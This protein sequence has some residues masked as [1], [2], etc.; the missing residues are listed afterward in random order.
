MSI[1]KRKGSPFYHYDF[2]WKGARQRGS[3]GQVKKYLADCMVSE[4]KTK[5]REK[6]VE[7]V[8]R[9]APTLEEFSKDFLEWV[10]AS[11]NIEENTRRVYGNGWR[12]LS[13]TKLAG[14]RM[15]EIANHHCETIQFPGSNYNANLALKTMRRMFSKAQEQKLVFNI[16]KIELRKVWGRS[17]AMSEEDA[18]RIAAQ[19]PE[20]DAKDALRILR[21]T[22]MRPCEAFAMRWEYVNAE[23]SIYRNPK[24]K[25]K[26]ARR[27]VPLFDPSGEILAR[28]RME[29]GS[30][31]EGWVFPSTSKGGHLVNIN[32]QFT[33]AR[34]AAGLPDGMVLYTARHGSLTDMAQVMT[35]CEVMQIGGHADSK[36][37]LRYQH[38]NTANI[39]ARLDNLKTSGRVQ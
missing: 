30:P 37:A 22:G 15:D 31:V 8:F 14:M 24:G 12:L 18:E 16:P 11:Q 1:Y 13:K 3:T 25:T 26:T 27:S 39:Q 20:G 35:L 9:K 28:R 17:I 7:G 23:K 36:T 32:K 21:A 38:P 2:T 19:M 4:L 29:Q 10:N 33:K 34:E 5:L 6:G